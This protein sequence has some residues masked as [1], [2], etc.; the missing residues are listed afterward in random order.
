MK[1]KLHIA[2][3][4]QE[5]LEIAASMLLT[6]PR[7]LDKTGYFPYMNLDYAFQELR[8]GLD[9]NRRTLGEER[10]LELTRMSA[11]MQAL[12]EADPEDETGGTLEGRK[13]ILQM[14]DILKQV[15]RKS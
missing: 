1:P 11:Q 2:Q 5:L 4:S 7:F 12:F 6:A 15:R 8:E 3:N 10:Y 13:I 9:H 14:E